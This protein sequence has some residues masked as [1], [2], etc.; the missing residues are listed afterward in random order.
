MGF[1]RAATKSE[2]PA[3]K[4]AEVQVGGKAGGARERG[5]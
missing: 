4:I 1:Q 2:I 3:G 5:W